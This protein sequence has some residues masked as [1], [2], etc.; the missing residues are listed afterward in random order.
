MKRLHLHFLKRMT[1]GLATFAAGI[2]SQT[3]MAQSNELSYNEDKWNAFITPYI[4][5]ESIKQETLC[6]TDKGREVEM[7]S[8]GRG[9][10]FRIFVTAR[11]N[12]DD[13]MGN[14]VIEGMV[15]GMLSKEDRNWFLG[16]TNIVVIPF[17]DKDGVEDK[18]H[19]TDYSARY[20][21]DGTPATKA[22]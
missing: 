3:S 15:E 21:G 22:I 19:G 1:L 11:H 20:G 18:A 7:L 13:A 4:D 17:V 9:G 2:L 14:Y 5:G 6:K 8:I 16:H 12:V 10:R